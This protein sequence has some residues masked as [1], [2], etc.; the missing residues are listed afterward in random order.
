MLHTTHELKAPFTAIEANMQL[1]SK[2]HCGVLSDDAIVVVR[3][4]SERC[5]RLGT[6][7]QEMLQLANL[8]SANGNSAEWV[9]LDLAEVLNWCIGQ[10]RQ[11]AEEHGII[12]ECNV[13][14]ARV[15]GVEDHLKML[16]S[17]LLANAVVYSREGGRVQVE[18]AH[19]SDGYTVTIQDSGIGI[20]SEKLPR[21]FDEYY[22]TK[23]A[24]R[25]NKRSTGL[26]LAIV[27]HIAEAQ[28]IRV[29]VE[30]LPGS[31]TKFVIR[32]A[33]LCETSHNEGK[34]VVQ[35]C[36]T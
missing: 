12:I 3:R 13:Q 34:E 32:F 25:H 2:G 15:V 35:E 31:G 36:R 23:E 22:R 17:N 9:D 6:E 10:V 21:I 8:H 33:S 19:G 18:S 29:R 4:V 5:R 26:G 16:F 30:S 1:L 14:P 7:I 24:V 27:R 11:T 20:Q 28:R